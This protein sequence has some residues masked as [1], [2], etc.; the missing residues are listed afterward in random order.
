MLVT[1]FENTEIPILFLFFHYQY[2]V[3]ILGKEV[4]NF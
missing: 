3:P 4:P 2:Y 1:Y